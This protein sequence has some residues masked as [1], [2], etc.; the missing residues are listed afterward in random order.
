M[1][2]HG[3]PG[4][5][6]QGT[7]G[8]ALWFSKKSWFLCLEGS[9]YSPCLTEKILVPLGP[10]SYMYSENMFSD[11][12]GVKIEISNTARKAPKFECL[13]LI[14]EAA[15]TTG[16]NWGSVPSYQGVCTS[17]GECLHLI[18]EGTETTGTG[19]S[20]NQG[21]LCVHTHSTEAY[22]KKKSG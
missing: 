1:G 15:E 12:N 9:F 11:C 20:A 21:R 8:F 18:S 22:H 19:E 7:K 4:R 2:K 6:G 13:H 16:T 17:T 5:E 3:G 10:I 14:S